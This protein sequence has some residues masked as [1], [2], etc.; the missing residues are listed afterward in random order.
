MERQ[1][2]GLFLASLEYLPLSCSLDDPFGATVE[3][4]AACN[5]SPDGEGSCLG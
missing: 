1:R 4:K 5:A 3:L 2:K